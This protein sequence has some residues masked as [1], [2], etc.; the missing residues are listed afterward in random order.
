MTQTHPF[1]LSDEEF[2]GKRV[3]VT[4]GCKGVDPICI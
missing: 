2:K 4:G 3:L 1:A